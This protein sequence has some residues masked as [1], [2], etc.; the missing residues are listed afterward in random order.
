MNRT[1]GLVPLGLLALLMATGVQA[2]PVPVGL[3]KWL[4]PLQVAEQRFEDG[5]LTIRM[6]K[7]RVPSELFTSVMANSICRSIL[8]N[9]KAWGNVEIRRVDI[10]NSFGV[11]GWYYDGPLRKDC[12]GLKDQSLQTWAAGDFWDHVHQK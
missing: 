4:K 12:Q 5:H 8:D 6:E 9:P 2:E 1:L 11:Q 10:V 7:A 3:A